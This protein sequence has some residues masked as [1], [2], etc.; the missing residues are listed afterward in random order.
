[1]EP[2]N[3]AHNFYRLN[4]PVFFCA[5]GQDSVIPPANVKKLYNM[6]GKCHPELA[7]LRMFERLGHA[8]FVLMTHDDVHSFIFST[9]QKMQNGT[10]SMA[11]HGGRSQLHRLSEKR[12]RRTVEDGPLW[13]ELAGAGNEEE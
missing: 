7:H 11:S 13:E 5:G 1:M 6:M 10:A 2:V 12:R 8:D 3:F 9:L 4:I